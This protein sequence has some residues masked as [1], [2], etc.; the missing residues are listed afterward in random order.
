MLN[1]VFLLN[2]NVQEQQDQ[3]DDFKVLFSLAYPSDC[4]VLDEKA[5]LKTLLSEYKPLTK[6]TNFNAIAKNMKSKVID[7]NNILYATLPNN[8]VFGLIFEDIEDNPYDYIDIFK[9]SLSELAGPLFMAENKI[10]TRETLTNI[11][12]TIFIEIK[13]W[14][15]EVLMQEREKNLPT[16][17]PMPDIT[18]KVFIYGLDN[19][20]KSSYIR[21]I[22]TGK[23]DKNF[24]P[25]TKQFRI[26]DL[27]Y[28]GMR[29][30][31]W[32][33]A[34]QKIFRK[35]WALSSQM[36]NIAIFFLDAAD[37][38]RYE[39]AKFAF[40]SIINNYDMIKIPFLFIVNKIDLKPEVSKESIIEYFELSKFKD[41]KWDVHL[42]SVEKSIGVN[43]SINWVMDTAETIEESEYEPDFI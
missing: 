18:I 21:F 1:K 2:L 28:Q 25:P 19:A 23:Y 38:E 8:Y 30:A 17:M 14:E 31:I 12:L 26:H 27:E 40:L 7:D 41:R 4:A 36:T 29:F 15:A 37:E 3:L 43:N 5:K 16:F 32:D 20:G 34:G 42:I 35:N 10:P 24:F 13:K 22:K 33:M 6:F 39:E 9:T 11:V